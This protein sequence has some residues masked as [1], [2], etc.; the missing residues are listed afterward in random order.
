VKN[1]ADKLCT[2]SRSTY[3]MFNNSFFP[4][5]AA[6]EIIWKFAVQQDRLQMT[7]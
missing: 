2:E 7:V 6:D 3:F 5:R 4:N 1:V